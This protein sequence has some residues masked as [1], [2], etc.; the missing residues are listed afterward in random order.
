MVTVTSKGTVTYTYDAVGNKLKKVVVDNSVNPSKTTTTEYLGLF[1]YQGDTLQ[2]VATEEGRVRPA[3]RIWYSDTMYYDYY[4]KDHLGNVRVTLTD[5]LQTDA[6][7][8]LSFD[9]T[10]GEIENQDAVWDN[11]DGNSIGLVR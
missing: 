6:Y 7:P 4:E 2:F 5:E 11:V 1:T 10:T 9:G 3:K 8:A